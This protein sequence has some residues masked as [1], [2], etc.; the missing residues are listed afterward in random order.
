M[1]YILFFFVLLLF[2]RLGGK[3]ERGRR[4]KLEGSKNSTH[5]RSFFFSL[6]K[7]RAD[8]CGS[9][10]FFAKKGESVIA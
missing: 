6:K 5:V 2:I 9:F 8:T 3:R 1:S 10:Y 7:Q 4:L